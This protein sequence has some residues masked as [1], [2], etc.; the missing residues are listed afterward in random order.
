MADTPYTDL[1]EG[2]THHFKAGALGQTGAPAKGNIPSTVPGTERFEMHV[3]NTIESVEDATPSQKSRGGGWYPG[4]NKDVQ[5]LAV[6]DLKHGVNYTDTRPGGMQG[7]TR[8]RRVPGDMF[9]VSPHGMEK[10]AAE[11]SS[12]SPARPAGMEWESAA[13]PGK[14]PRKMNVPAAHQL[15]TITPEQSKWLDTALTANAAQKKAEGNRRKASHAPGG[16]SAA[17]EG[18]RT[19]AQQPIDDAYRAA[20]ADFKKKSAKARA[21][22]KDTPLGHAGIE[23]IAKGRDI[24]QDKYDKPLEALGDMKERSFAH[25]M[26]RP[27]DAEKVFNG[28]SGTIDEHQRNVME[29]K[30]VHHVWK[31]SAT[32]PKQPPRTAPSPGKKLGY[33]YGRTVLH[34]A[35]RRMNMRPNEAQ[36]TSWISEKETKPRGR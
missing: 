13:K 2:R 18:P 23:A 24:S 22:F 1:F 31:E 15:K 14:P 8:A 29:G 4:A 16:L 33:E 25:D 17:A 7:I 36:P 11:I 12:T 28:E 21:P 10:A 26:L 30:G 19:E 9:F 27:H 35:A 20:Q 32:T 6:S 34:E 5:D 3:R